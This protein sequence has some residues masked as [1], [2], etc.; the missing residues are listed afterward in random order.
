MTTTYTPTQPPNC[1]R[2]VVAGGGIAGLSTAWHLQRAAAEADT[3]LHVTVLE[4]GDRW[5]GKIHTE[6]VPTAASEPYV[7]EA[8]PDSFITQKPAALRMAQALGL[9]DDELLGTNDAMRRVFVLN[10]GKPVVLPDGVLLIVPTKFMPFA[11]S[12]L[13]T[14]LGKLRMGLDW[15]I[16]RKQDERDETLSD[17]I[18]RRLGTEALDKIAEPLMSGIYNADAEQQSVEA[19]FPRF[20]QIERKYGSL[21]RGMLAARRKRPPARPDADRKTS[22][23]MSFKGGMNALVDALIDDL[24]DADLR[25][26]SKIVQVTHCDD[27]SY[28]VQVEDGTLLQAD[29]VVMATP[30]FVTADLLRELVP[31]AAALLSDIRYVSTGTV[32]LAYRRQDITKPINGFG[33][34]IPKTENRPINAI[35]VSSTKFDHRAPDD[36]VLL[37]VFF[38]G[39]RRPDVMHYDDITLMDTIRAELKD[40]LGISAAPQMHRIYRWWRSNP[41]YDVDHLARVDAIEALLPPGLYVTGSAYRGVGVPDCVEQAEQTAKAVID[42]AIERVRV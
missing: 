30:A 6:T 9:G 11:L 29:A 37:R 15:F 34:V 16:P 40:L 27:G 18:T 24:P 2:V 39:S 32:T 19:T 8:G 28:A 33:L 7:V 25:L 41:Q 21:I 14:P 1:L 35:T 20:Q 13:I 5:G 12:P 3:P 23:F 22:M 38:G 31:G 17:F 42:A 36:T 4:S 26:D 10:R